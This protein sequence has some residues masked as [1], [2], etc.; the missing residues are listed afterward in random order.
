MLNNKICRNQEGDGLAKTERENR[1]AAYKRNVG[2]AR[3]SPS[4]RLVRLLSDRGAKVSHND[5][6]IPKI[7]LSQGE[8]T[9]VVL[10]KGNLSSADGAVTATDHSCIIWMK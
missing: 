4:L 1:G 9:S 5:P 2:D 10:T 3:G 7:E 8:L 6:C